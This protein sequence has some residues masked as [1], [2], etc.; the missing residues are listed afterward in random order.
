VLKNVILE[1]YDVLQD[2]VKHVIPNRIITKLSKRQLECFEEIKRNNRDSKHPFIQ[3]GIIYK[4]IFNRDILFA[5][6][7]F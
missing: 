7:Y 3:T 2:R 5:L 6:K 4:N 1:L